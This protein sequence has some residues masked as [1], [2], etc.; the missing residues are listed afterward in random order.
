MKGILALAFILLTFTGCANISP[1]SP[2]LRNDIDNQNGQIE[3]IKNNQNGFMLDLLNLRNEQSVQ[4][5]D[6]ENVQQ[7][8]INKTNKNSGIQILQGD[9]ALVMIFALATVGML[10]IYH[11]KTKAVRNEKT[12]EILAQ[13]IAMYDDVTLDDDVFVAA[14][15]TDVEAD[16]YHLMVKSQAKCGKK[17]GYSSNR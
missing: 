17:Q 5:R 7:G 13:Q 11:Y 9:G 14:M 3:D 8:L 15:N 6:I 10:L 12:A 4:A 1:F 16:I 2:E